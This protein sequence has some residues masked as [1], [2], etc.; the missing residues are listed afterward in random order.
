MRSKEVKRGEK[1]ESMSEFLLS[2]FFLGSVAIKS[3]NFH[4]EAKLVLFFFPSPFCL[5]LRVELLGAKG[6][7]R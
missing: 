6:A 3:E 1:Q 4:V 7:P 5:T 2:L